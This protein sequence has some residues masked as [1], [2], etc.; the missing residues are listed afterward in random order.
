MPPTMRFELLDGRAV[1]AFSRT[2]PPLKSPLF[3]L[4]LES[5]RT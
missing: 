2:N 3:E 5:Y 1:T 4:F